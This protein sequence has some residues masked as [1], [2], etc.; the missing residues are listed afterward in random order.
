MTVP[1]FLVGDVVGRAL[2]PVAGHGDAAR[3]GMAPVAGGER[4]IGQSLPDALGRGPDVGAVD[5][6]GSLAVVLGRVHGSRGL[7][8]R[9]EIGQGLGPGPVVAVDPAVGDVVDGGGVEVVQLLPPLPQCRDQPGRL[10]DG[11]VLGHRLAGHAHALAELGEGEAAV[12]VQPIEQASPGGVAERPED[13][14]HIWHHVCRAGAFR[15]M[16]PLGCVFQSS[17]LTVA[18]QGVGPCAPGGV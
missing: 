10:E 1:V 2:L 13:R 8:C 9:L 17:S 15:F 18:C 11:Q 5:E 4:R 12:L 6:G 14:I 16:Q 3:G 7:Q